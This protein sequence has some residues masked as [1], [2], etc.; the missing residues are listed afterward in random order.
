MSLT[1]D[2]VQ[3]RARLDRCRGRGARDRAPRAASRPARPPRALLERAAHDRGRRRP[4][5]GAP[6]SPSPGCRTRAW[7]STSA[8]SLGRGP[9]RGPARRPRRA[10]VDDLT[11]DPWVST[12]PGIAH[13]CGHDVHTA[14]LVG[15]GLALA[16]VHRRGEL[17]GR[18]RLLFQPAEEVMP[19]GATSLIE[20]GALDEVDQI[21]CLHCDPTLDLGQVGRP[22]GSDH[23]SGRP[24]RGPAHRQRRPHLAPAPHRGPHLRPRQADHRAAGRAVAPPRPAGRRQRGVGHGPR[25]RRP[26]RDPGR[27]RRRRHRAHARRRGLVARRA[28]GAR[29]TSRTSWRRTA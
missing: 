16:E 11:T 24:A 14:G 17:P 13:A 26:Q 2:Y 21:F 4:P 3:F 20:L 9:P 6:A 27:R 18:V 12:R 22:R 1:R 19:G 25:G 23:R 8:T 15:A 29:A 7:S 10:P 28:A 5:G